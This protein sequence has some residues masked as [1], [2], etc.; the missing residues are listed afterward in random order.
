MKRIFCFVSIIALTFVGYSFGQDVAVVY[1]AKM[2]NGGGLGIA[3]GQAGAQG[4]AELIVE[5]LEDEKL[6]AEIVDSDGLLEYMEA[7]PKGI[8]IITQGNTPETIFQNKGKDDPIYSWLRDGGI[9]GFI[10]DYPFYYYWDFGANNRVEIT[11]AGQRSVFGFQVTNSNTASV[12]PTDLGKKY[13]PSLKKWTSNRPAGL[14]VLEQNDFEFESYA[15]DGTNADP[16]AYRTKDMKGWFIN[17]HTS[18]CGTAIP[19]NEQVATEYAELIANRFGEELRSV[20]PAE[21]V[22]VVWGQLKSLR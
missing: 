14:N 11:G 20:D 15:D 1:D 21:K 12:S 17:F 13:I 2:E 10:G 4:L 8:Y 6:D 22:S 19:G 5:K 16:I 7:N 3:G 18:C 9:G